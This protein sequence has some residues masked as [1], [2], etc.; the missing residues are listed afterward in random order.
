MGQFDIVL[1]QVI[2]FI[3]M[4]IVGFVAVKAGVINNDGLTVI[5]KLVTKV[6]L[7]FL[8]FI[9]AVNGATRETLISNLYIA[10]LCL[11]I[12][13]VLIFVGRLLPKMLRM[14]GERANIF[15]FF[16]TFGNVGYVGI[17]LVLAM[18]GGEGMLIISIFTV[19]DQT[20]YWTYGVSLTF[21]VREKT[22]LNLKSLKNMLNPPFVSVIL[23]LICIL[24]NVKLP[25]VVHQ[26]F[27]T[28]A[29]GGLAL[30][31]IFLGGM[32]AISDM[33]KFFGFHQIYVGIVVKMILFPIALFLA[34]RALGFAEGVIA[35]LTYIFALPGNAMS[36]ML[37][38]TNGSDEEFATAG[39]L[40]TMLAGL[41]TLTF[42]S[43]MIS[44]VL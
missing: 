35:P 36:P 24:L 1:N 37:A 21:P 14:K 9:N 7:P 13:I 41:L 2:M 20:L 12:Y 5:S 15:S 6:T 18:F 22:R 39:V 11:V 19:V 38:R 40:I 33:K 31:F 26:A 44:V 10:L 28:I 42:L 8:M 16:N 25:S 23:A 4:L 34:L 30:P 27:S 17:P 3:I 32:L 43:Y 29:N